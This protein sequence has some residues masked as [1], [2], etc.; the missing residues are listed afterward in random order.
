M[1]KI[2][3]QA[4]RRQ[5]NRLINGHL[6]R[7]KKGEGIL[8]VNPARFDEMSKTFLR[9]KAK[10]IQLSPDELLANKKISPEAHQETQGVQELNTP[11]NLEP[12]IEGSG[13]VSNAGGPKG[14]RVK[15]IQGVK[16]GSY[17]MRSGVA[18]FEANKATAGML[19]DAITAGKE[20]KLVL[21]D[22]SNRSHRQ[23]KGDIGVGGNILN[24]RELPPALRSQPFSANFQ[25]A[26]QLPPAYQRYSRGV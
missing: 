5:M 11:V 24:S 22:K 1:K 16:Q 3:I 2:G 21:H 8:L 12:L 19:Y 7:V 17:L 25:F 6:V 13:F 26:N 9:G 23:P 14:I 18:N 20:N 4:S 15:T 10:Q